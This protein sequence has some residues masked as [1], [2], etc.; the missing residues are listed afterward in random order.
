MVLCARNMKSDAVYNGPFET[1]A[2]LWLWIRLR[3]AW[4]R[5]CFANIVRALRMRTQT[6]GRNLKPNQKPKPWF[7][8]GACYLYG[9]R[10]AIEWLYYGILFKISN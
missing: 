6:N 5:G 4:L 1:T 7:R 9:Y 10:Y 3:L 2:L 8:K